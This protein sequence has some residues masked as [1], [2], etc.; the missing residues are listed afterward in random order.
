MKN[1]N[2][3]IIDLIRI[4]VKNIKTVI[5]FTIIFSIIFT[6]LINRS[7]LNYKVIYAEFFLKE[8]FFEKLKQLEQ[9]NNN[10]KIKF[11]DS[12]DDKKIYNDTVI[13]TSEFA[14]G[15]YYDALVQKFSSNNIVK[16]LSQK[17]VKSEYTKKEN[18]NNIN[19]LKVYIS[20]E[21]SFYNI[22]NLEKL[23]KQIIEVNKFLQQNY[24]EKIYDL[25]N[26]YL[27][28]AKANIQKEIQKLEYLINEK[29]NWRNDNDDYFIETKNNILIYNFNN[30]QSDYNL[31]FLSVTALENKIKNLEKQLNRLD[32]FVL[33]EFEDTIKY[34]KDNNL[35]YYDN[36]N[37]FKEAPPS[38][39][40][41]ELFYIF[42]IILSF[43]F[44]L[45]ITLLI[46]FYKKS[47]I[48]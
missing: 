1:S 31:L 32:P 45:I 4:W 9:F 2:L 28:Y 15:Q 17:F 20:L 42:T 39:K 47:K 35:I 21:K 37:L 46:N 18:T 38:Y 10:E 23:K 13:T 25:K 12:L 33:N 48:K 16:S 8:N 40:E 44:S 19:F 43:L 14:F 26:E 3:N 22:E 29:K 7:L 24:T 5:F 30:K 27:K 41:G 11:F 34:F 36:N 6:S